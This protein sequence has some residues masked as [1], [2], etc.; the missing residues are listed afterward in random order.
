[1]GYILD[2]RKT[3]GHRPLL[4][5]GASVIIEDDQGRTLLQLRSD[6]HCWGYHGGSVELDERV[7][8]AARR[9]LYEETGLTAG[10]MTLF[11]VFSGPELHNVYPNGDETSCVDVVYLCR[12]YAGELRCQP[13]EVEALRFFPA[14]QLPSPLSPPTIP[15]LRLWAEG[16]KK[17]KENTWKE[18]CL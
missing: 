3:V 13:G 18:P 5:V 4:Q 2:L 9:E 11:G 8:D 15:A 1:M 7:E 17:E 10:R 6:S 12:D 14:D 16:K